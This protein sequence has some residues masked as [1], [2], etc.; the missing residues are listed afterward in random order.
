MRSLCTTAAQKTHVDKLLKLV[1]GKTLNGGQ[2]WAAFSAPARS[3]S[4]KRKGKPDLKVDFTAA[5]VATYKKLR[6]TVQKKLYERC[7]GHCSYCRMAV[8][9]YGWAWHIEHV[10]PKAKYPAETF[11]LSNLTVACVHCNCWKGAKVDKH[12]VGKIMSIIDPSIKQFNYADHLHFVQL[13]TEDFAFSK[14]L[15]H[16]PAGC[17]TYDKLSFSE[18]ER[19]HAINGLH[20]RSMGVH[21]RLSRLM[22]S[23]LS[24]TDRGEL[25]DF[26]ADLKSSIYRK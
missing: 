20:G 24:A 14:Y 26:L 10:Q 1:S 15:P 25:V 16:S 6:Q 4:F 5:E 13:G 11:R 21:D 3:K 8:G 2:A 7:A 12:V 23:G 18:L 22:Q 19:A 9:H 17:E